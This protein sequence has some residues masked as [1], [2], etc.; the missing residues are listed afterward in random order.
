MTYN[1]PYSFVPGTKAKADEVNANFIYLANGLDDTN[2]RIDSCNTDITAVQEN[3]DDSS[4][5]LSSSIALKANSTDLDGNWT[6]K[7]LK[8][9]NSVNLYNASNT[10]ASF[11][12]ANYL[13]SGGALYQIALKGSVT[14]GTTAGNYAPMALTTDWTN[15]YGYSICSARAR[16]AASVDACGSMIVIAKTHINMFRRSNYNGTAT[17]ELFGYRKVR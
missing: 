2:D 1:V 6:F 14:T 3:L 8:L 9:I 13:P 17:V 5:S 10:T 7:Y 11:S 4:S 15:G 16:T 12:L